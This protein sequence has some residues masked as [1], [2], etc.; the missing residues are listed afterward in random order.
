MSAAITWLAKLGGGVYSYVSSR[1]DE[2]STSKNLNFTTGGGSRGRLST[3]AYLEKV[4][5]RGPQRTKREK[6]RVLSAKIRLLDLTQL[7]ANDFPSEL[8][9]FE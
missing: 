7:T 1:S 2:S 4:Q 8:A 5:I 6:L 3:R 9:T